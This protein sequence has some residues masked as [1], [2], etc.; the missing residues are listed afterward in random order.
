MFNTDGRMNT[1]SN[2]ESKLA[3]FNEEDFDDDARETPAWSLF[4]WYRL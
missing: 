1:K 2:P 3:R 4:K